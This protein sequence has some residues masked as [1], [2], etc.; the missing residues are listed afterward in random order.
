MN[1]PETQEETN[2]NEQSE[3]SWNVIII[4][5]YFHKQ[6]RGGGRAALFKPAHRAAAAGCDHQA[7][8][9]TLRLL[10]G[11]CFPEASA[12]FSFLLLERRELQI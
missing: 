11:S 4:S 5:L 10:C 9:E 1:E 2:V 8:V 3:D 12:G 6:R 7:A